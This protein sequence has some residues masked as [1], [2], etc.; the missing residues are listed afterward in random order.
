MGCAV[1]GNGDTSFGQ[2]SLVP[3][4]AHILIGDVGEPVGP[5]LCG[6]LFG[7]CLGA[8]SRA[9]LQHEAGEAGILFSRMSLG[10]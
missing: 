4:L 3:E 9:D 1:G 5:H 2:M 6:D 8:Q 10:C 7:L